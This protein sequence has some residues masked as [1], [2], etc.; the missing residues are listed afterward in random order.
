[1]SFFLFLSLQMSKSRDGSFFV[2]VVGK[3]NR[4]PFLGEEP[5]FCTE[6]LVLEDIPTTSFRDPR[7]KML[8]CFGSE[9]AVI[10]RSPCSPFQVYWESL[11]K[12]I[13]LTG[14]WG[15]ASNTSCTESLTPAAPDLLV[16]DNRGCGKEQLFSHRP[17]TSYHNSLLNLKRSEL[18]T[19]GC[20]PIV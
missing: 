8:W 17:W 7:H 12:K 6:I 13:V 2:V 20:D 11:L 18:N 14:K 19:I 4:L 16:L 10:T 5:E 9:Q 1:M 3:R 15:L